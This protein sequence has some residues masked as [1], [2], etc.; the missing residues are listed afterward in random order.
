VVG[1]PQRGAGAV[2]ATVDGERVRQEQWAF[3]AV[4]EL[5]QRPLLAGG[6][7]GEQRRDQRAVDDQVRIAL[8]VA[9]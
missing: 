1:G 8:D 3:R 6:E 2:G 5:A 9:R 7:V 4:G